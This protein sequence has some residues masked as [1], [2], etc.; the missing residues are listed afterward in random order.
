MFVYSQ[1]STWLVFSQL[2]KKLSWLPPFP[3]HICIVLLTSLPVI[4][5]LAALLLLSSFKGNNIIIK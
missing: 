2:G 1:E 4:P 5:S 3:V